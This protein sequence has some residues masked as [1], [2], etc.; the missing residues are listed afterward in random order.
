MLY[1]YTDAREYLKRA[2]TSKMPP[3]MIYAALTG[4]FQGKEL[5]PALPETPE[6]QAEESRRCYEAGAVMVHIHARNP[7]TG[8]ARP[9]GRKEDYAK[10]NQ[11][12]RSRCPDIII[13]NT[14][15]GGLGL[16]LEERLSSLDAGPEV[17][18]IDMGPLAFALK[19]RRRL[20]PLSGRDQDEFTDGVIPISVGETELR[21]KRMKERG[22]VPTLAL[23]HSGHWSTVH[24]LID[25]GL[26]TPPYNFMFLLGM[27]GGAL[28]TPAC[29]LDLLR[30]APQPS[31]AFICG[32]SRHELPMTAMASLLG[33]HVMIGMETNLYV[34]EGVLADSNARLVE[35]AV[36]IAQDL[37]RKIATP[38]QAREMLGVSSRPSQYSTKTSPLEG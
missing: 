14:S 20:P 13:D 25:K 24:N 30:D 18:D 38:A 8:Y 5:N 4:G 12:I 27:T 1:D 31:N 10:V 22:I 7:E 35:R 9:T 2:G 33:L 28:A 15:G 3:F 21:A 34:K 11:L 19:L 17:S 37:G 29:L 26:I 23:F 6:E 16:T 32:V 36:R